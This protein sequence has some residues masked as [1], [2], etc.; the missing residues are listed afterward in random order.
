ME[1]A[2]ILFFSQA[3]TEEL[4]LSIEMQSVFN[5]FIN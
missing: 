3:L 2:H 1:L 4:L 5:G